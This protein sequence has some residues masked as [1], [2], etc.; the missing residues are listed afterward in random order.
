MSLFDPSLTFP[1]PDIIE[2][3][4][5]EE[6]IDRT[7]HFELNTSIS[8]A[9]RHMAAAVMKGSVCYHTPMDFARIDSIQNL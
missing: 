9:K 4:I 7:D 8:V 6:I 1:Y 2:E 5:G 3:I